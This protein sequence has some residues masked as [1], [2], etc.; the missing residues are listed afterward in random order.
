MM[1]AVILMYYYVAVLFLISYKRKCWKIERRIRIRELRSERPFQLIRES[2]IA[3]I[4]ELRM[5]RRTFHILC[6]MLR[7]VGG[8]EDTRNMSL[9]VSVASFLY[10]LSHHLKNRTIGTFYCLIYYL[11]ETMHQ[12]NA[13]MGPAVQLNAI[14]INL[15]EHK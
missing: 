1:I 3:C 14:G 9:E 2:D 4:S 8:I 5:D 7:D 15:R 6:D 10:I 11:S 13:C 12:Y